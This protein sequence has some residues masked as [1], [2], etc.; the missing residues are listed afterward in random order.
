M[1]SQFASSMRG[2]FSRAAEKAKE[3]KNSE[4]MNSTLTN[5]KDGM[6]NVGNSE[7]M[8]GIKETV[9]EIASDVRDTHKIVSDL[10]NEYDQ[11]MDL[12]QYLQKEEDRLKKE[13]EEQA[14][15]EAEA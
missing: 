1:A 7:F 6:Q 10:R 5:M 11:K 15:A 9:G 8:Q 12:D 13:E 4:V 2:F 14:L 3:V